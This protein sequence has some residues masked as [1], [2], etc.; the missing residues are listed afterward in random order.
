MTFQP[1]E[2]FLKELVY[3]R[4]RSSKTAISYRLAAN[5]YLP[6]LPKI[7][8]EWTS[9]TLNTRA[10]ALRAQGLSPV[11]FNVYTR[12]FN[13]FLHWLHDQQMTDTHLKI[14]LAKEEKK[15][16]ST[17]SPSAVHALLTE[18]KPKRL[19]ERR[20][21]AF[22]YLLLD[23]GV[24]ADEAL[25][26]TREDLDFENLL[27]HVQGKGNKERIIPMSTEGR[28]VLYQWARSHPYPYIFPCRAGGQV[29]Y[30]NI[31]RDFKGLCSRL[32]VTGVRAS[33]H[34]LRHT[35]ATNYIAKGG[36]VLHL[37]RILGHTTLTM[38]QRYVHLQTQDLADVH[39]KYT[40]VGPYRVPAGGNRSTATRNY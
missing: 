25:T 15:T 31:L 1:L 20:L 9:K 2:D 7:P 14:P 24:R 17:F 10:V 6:G 37:Q 28:R 4:N 18:W 29:R 21:Y 5:T 11:T 26:L 39:E 32:G 40:S 12:S 38:T 22:V 3:L 33:F 36:S 13:V 27:V 19:A 8:S 30:R 16:P 23:T 35:F 34:T